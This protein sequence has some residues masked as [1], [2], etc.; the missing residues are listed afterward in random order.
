MMAVELEDFVKCYHWPASSVAV[1]IA[2]KNQAS[3]LPIQHASAGV[4]GGQEKPKVWKASA[5][6]IGSAKPA[7]GRG[8]G[9]SPA[10]A[11]PEPP[12]VWRR[13]SVL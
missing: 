4:G 10:A 12:Y 13:W 7:S 1:I 5:R 3:K 9:R 8:S 11:T 2:D 6:V